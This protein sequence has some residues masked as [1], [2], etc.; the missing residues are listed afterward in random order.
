MKDTFS[1][2]LPLFCEHQ[3]GSH[4]KRST[5]TMNFPFICSPQGSKYS[6]T[7]LHSSFT[8]LLTISAEFFL[9]QSS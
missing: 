9:L 4:G 2:F 6:F 7:G 5:G 3:V 1:E 8:D